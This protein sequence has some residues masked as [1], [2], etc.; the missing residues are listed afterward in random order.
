MDRLIAEFVQHLAV[1]RNL[2]T[3]TGRAYRQDLAEFRAFLHQERAGLA[4]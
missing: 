4:V 1:E 2:S 3:H